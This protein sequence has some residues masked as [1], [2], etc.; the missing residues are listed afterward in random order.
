[1]KN[2]KKSAGRV[3]LSPRAL[4]AAGLA[5]CVLLLILWPVSY[6]HLESPVTGVVQVKS[7]LRS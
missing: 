3:F 2:S 6:T 4:Q 7:D 1:M 5:G